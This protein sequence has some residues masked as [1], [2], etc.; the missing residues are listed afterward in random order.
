MASQEALLEKLL[1]N[2]ANYNNQSSFFTNFT[3][4]IV[5]SMVSQL[6]V[7]HQS[8]VFKSSVH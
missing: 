3:I 6:P 2:S 1:V 5:F 4:S 8:A 7:A